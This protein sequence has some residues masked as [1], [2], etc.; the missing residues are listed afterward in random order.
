MQRQSQMRSAGITTALCLA[1]LMLFTGPAVAAPAAAEPFTKER[2]DELTGRGELVLVVVSASWCPTCAQ[3]RTILDAYAAQRPE[4]PLRM[5]NVDFDSQKEWVI[6]FKAPRQ[7]TLIL[8]DGS[9]QSWFSVA[10]TRAD[11]IARVLDAA[12]AERTE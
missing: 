8:Y 5:L 3:Q 6:H 10:E 4:S 9:E 11:Q 2:F 7:S 12:V 1:L